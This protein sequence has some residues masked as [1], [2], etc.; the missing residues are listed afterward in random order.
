ML[1]YG[2]LQ[3]RASKYTM[4]K[5]NIH[6][7]KNKLLGYVLDPNLKKKE[8]RQIYKKFGHNPKILK[9]KLREIKELHSEI[10]IRFRNFE[11][12]GELKLSENKGLKV[13]V[14]ELWRRGHFATEYP[15][16]INPK[17]DV[18]LNLSERLEACLNNI[19]C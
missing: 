3:I 15:E 18:Y 19:P 5:G 13:R 12:I 17:K 7:I 1:K 14:S 2:I 4:C 10:T 11:K 6:D 16:G 8:I 9:T